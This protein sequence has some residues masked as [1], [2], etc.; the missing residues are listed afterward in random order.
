MSALLAVAAGGA[1]G[2]AGRWVAVGAFDR[3][4]GAGFPFGTL[5]VNILG[6]FAMGA[7]VEAGL[8]GWSPSPELRAAVAAGVLGGFTTF[9]AFALDVAALTGRGAAL[10]AGGYVVLSVVLSVAGLVAGAGVA[11]WLLA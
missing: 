3:W 7:L 4:L 8:R 11:R 5:A 6:S 10:A 9:S 1:L 2:A